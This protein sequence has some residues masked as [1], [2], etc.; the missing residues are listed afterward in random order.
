[1]VRFSSSSEAESTGLTDRMW[2]VSEK[3]G[4]KGDSRVLAWAPGKKELPFTEMTKITEGTGLGR[5]EQ[6]MVSLRGSLDIHTKLSA[7]D[8]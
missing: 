5:E 2:T 1:M 4:A 7:D 8:V 3:T 6:D